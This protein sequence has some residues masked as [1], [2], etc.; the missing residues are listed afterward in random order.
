MMTID[1]RP[2][3]GHRVLGPVRVIL[4]G[5]HVRTPRAGVPRRDLGTWGVV[6]Q[7]VPLAGGTP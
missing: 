1:A 2:L 7:S 3:A 6:G 5:L 4:S